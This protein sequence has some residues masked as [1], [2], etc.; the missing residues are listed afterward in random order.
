MTRTLED[1]TKHDDD[2]DATAWERR[3]SVGQI[4]TYD[5]PRCT[6]GLDA[7]L[8][9]PAPVLGVKQATVKELIRQY[10]S[11]VAE[12]TAILKSACDREW[13]DETPI[14]IAHIAANAIYWRDQEIAKLKAVRLAAQEQ[15][16]VVEDGRDLA[17]AALKNSG[18]DIDC[19]ACMEVA[20]TGVTMARH[21]CHSH[22]PVQ[23]EF[24]SRHESEKE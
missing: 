16:S 9:A 2:C 15:P 4:P 11:V 8:A 12:M 22:V 20:F 18:I 17:I 21:T 3:R 23:V 5:R 10:D 7:L 19:G 13:E 14:Q 1:Y 24:G 6:C